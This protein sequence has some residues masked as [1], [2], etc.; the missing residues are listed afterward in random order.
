MNV[1]LRQTEEREL[2]LQTLRKS[3]NDA[4]TEGGQVTEE[5]IDAA[6]DVVD[7]KMRRRGY[8]E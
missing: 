8:A 4:I 6:L 7:E 5:E 1:S 3:I 2:K